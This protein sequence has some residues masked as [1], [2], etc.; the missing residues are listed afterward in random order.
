MSRRRQQEQQ[1]DISSDEMSLANF[2]ED[3]AFSSSDDESLDKRKPGF[4]VD[5]KDS[6]EEELERFV[7][8][9]KETFREQLF[10]DDF[11]PSVT[12][13]K[14]LVKATGDDDATGHEHISDSMLFTLDTGDTDDEDLALAPAK[15]AQRDEISED[16]PAWE[17][18]DDERLTVSL[19][20]ATR[21]RKLRTTEAEDVVSGTEYATR[22]RQQYLRLYPVPEWAK[23]PTGSKRRRRRS[24][25]AS[26]SASGSDMDVDSDGEAIDS[27]APLDAFLRDANSFRPTAADGS[28]RRKLRPETLDIQRTRDIPDVHKAGVSSLAFHPRHPILLSASTSSIM[29]LHQIDAAAHPVP[30]PALTSV[31]VKRTDL[32]RAAFL[33]PAGDEVVFAGRRRYFH[34]WNLSSGLVKKIS[35]IQGHQKEHRTMERFRASP[36]GRYLALAASDKKGGGML[37]VVNAGS[38]QWVAQARIDGRGGVS[39]FAWWS[40]GNGLT[41][42]GKDG[43]VTEWSVVTRRTVG[44]WRDEGSIGGTVMALGGRNGPAGLGGDRWVAVGSNSGIVNVYDRN[45]LLVKSAKGAKL[46]DAAV[47]VKKLP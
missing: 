32:R 3:D 9:G 19:A 36:C 18:S 28:K 39:D 1:E 29:Y 25:A 10:R 22:L 33:G 27:A 31:Q 2:D 37:N 12:D 13:S 15:Q 46:D 34:S 35:K 45:E 24:S 42:A 23:A 47:E 41:I 30:N 16:P 26:D 21:L 20:G 44:V 5:D 6:D 8:G 4:I 7:L 38:M 43:Q 17:D 11:L 40:D 14:A